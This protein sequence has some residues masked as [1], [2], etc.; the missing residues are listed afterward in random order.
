MKA[1]YSLDCRLKIGNLNKGKNLSKEIIEK[2]R[3]KA[4]NRKKTISY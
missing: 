2:I 4:L 3:E 1:N